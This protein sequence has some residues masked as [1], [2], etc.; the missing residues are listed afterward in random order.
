MELIFE[1]KIF[2]NPTTSADEELYTFEKLISNCRN[3]KKGRIFYDREFLN[4]KPFFC[5]I[6]EQLI[7]FV[8][9]FDPY[10]IIFKC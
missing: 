4:K 5:S 1:N 10:I 6:S 2:F 7:R 8:R 3:I 9:Y